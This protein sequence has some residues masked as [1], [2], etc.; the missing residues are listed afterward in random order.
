VL[1]EQI[2]EEYA[3][4]RVVELVKR[5]GGGPIKAYKV[6]QWMHIPK[7]GVKELCTSEAAQK[8]L[9]YELVQRDPKRPWVETPM[10]T[11]V[12]ESE[13]EMA[14][15]ATVNSVVQTP[16]AEEVTEYDV[17]PVRKRRWEVSLLTI[18]KVHIEADNLLEAHKVAMTTYPDTTDIVGVTEER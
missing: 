7:D 13:P 2:H 3:L 11:L 8:V 17:L 12:T 4:W 16:P 18:V 9:R 10:I 5:D 1:D 15:K 6:S 14:T